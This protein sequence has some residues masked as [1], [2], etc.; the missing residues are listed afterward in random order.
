MVLVDDEAILTAMR[1]IWNRLKIVVEPSAAV[2]LAAMLL[3]T[4]RVPARPASF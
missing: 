1:L 2:C 3:D 4:K